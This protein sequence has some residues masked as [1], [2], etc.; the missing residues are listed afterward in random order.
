MKEYWQMSN[1]TFCQLMSCIVSSSPLPAFFSQNSI[2]VVGIIYYLP[3]R[4][5]LILLTESVIFIMYFHRGKNHFSVFSVFTD[6]HYAVFTE[7]VAWNLWSVSCF[8]QQDFDF[9]VVEESQPSGSAWL[10]HS[11][12]L[13]SYL[14]LL[15]SSQ[16]EETQEA[17]CGVLQNLTTNEGI[18]GCL[19]CS[20]TAV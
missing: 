19:K 13:Q 3:L 11:K 4:A 15:N 12:T 18:V 10:I 1:L 6:V 7:V 8:V 20:L 2:I 5:C 16:Q 14:V 9:P 17:C